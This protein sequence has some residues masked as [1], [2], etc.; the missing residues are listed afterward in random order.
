MVLTAKI[1]SGQDRVLSYFA[2]SASHSCTHFVTAVHADRRPSS[3]KSRFTGLS[4]NS[5]TQAFRN[6][7]KG[8]AAKITVQK[9]PAESKRERVLPE[10]RQQSTSYAP[11]SADPTRGLTP[12]AAAHRRRREH[13]HAG[14]Q[15][16][17]SGPTHARARRA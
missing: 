6:S 4:A 1:L 11:T 13:P 10:D 3:E 2:R 5:K 12:G 17:L 15:V 16:R 7:A 14:P 9:R 8:K